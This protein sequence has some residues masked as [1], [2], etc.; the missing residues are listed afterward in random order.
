MK[1]IFS[2]FISE[3]GVA[4]HIHLLFKNLKIIYIKI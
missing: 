1:I 2:W 3:E 4:I